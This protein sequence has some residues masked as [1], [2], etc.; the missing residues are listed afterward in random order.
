M[1]CLCCISLFKSN[2]EIPG[3]KGETTVLSAKH[4]STSIPL[5]ISVVVYIDFFNHTSFYFI[6]WQKCIN[7]NPT[8]A[9]HS[10]DNS[11]IS[12]QETEMPQKNEIKQ[13]EN[14]D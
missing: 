7:W 8:N 11:N 3:D 12:F 14:I 4:G 1:E 10:H 5:P 2:N 13:N 9:L 6:F